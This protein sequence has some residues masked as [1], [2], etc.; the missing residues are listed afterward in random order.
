M[1]KHFA[2][3]EDIGGRILASEENSNSKRGKGEVT[4]RRKWLTILAAIAGKL[5]KKKC[6]GS[7]VKTNK[8]VRSN[9]NSCGL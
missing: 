8:T 9:Q 2:A 6:Q 7:V 3:A 1:A 5:E 4:K